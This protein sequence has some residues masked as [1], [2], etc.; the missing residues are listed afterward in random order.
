[1]KDVTIMRSRIVYNLVST[2]KG[3]AA[4]HIIFDR[5]WLHG[6]DN[7]ETTRGI[8]RTPRIGVHTIKGVNME[9]EGVIPDVLVEPHPDDLARGVDRQLQKAVEVLTQDVSAWKKTR[10]PAVGASGASNP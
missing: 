9:K 3:G 10:P 6:T 1:M 7:D 4:D 5:V 8:I 2:D